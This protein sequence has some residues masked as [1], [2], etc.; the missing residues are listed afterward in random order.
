[1]LKILHISDLHFGPPF[2]PEV[3]E[4]VLR[5]AEELA[6]GIIVASGDFTQ[7]AKRRQFAEARDFLDRLPPVP[8]VVTP[9]NHDMPLY[10]VWERLLRPYANYCQYISPQLDTV[11]ARDDAVIVSLNTTSPLWAITNG[12]IDRW[13]LDFCS[14]A[15]RDVPDWRRGSWLPTIT[16]R[17][18]PTTTTSTTSCGG[19]ARRWIALT[20]WEWN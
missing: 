1:M 16:S 20:S 19:P 10:R 3:G 11:L 12:R 9:G 14:D 17:R 4:A 15:F 8:V 6:P 13:Q 5:A 18:R 2:V 7:R